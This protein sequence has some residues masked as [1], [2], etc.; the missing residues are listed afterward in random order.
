MARQKTGWV[1]QDEKERWFYRFQYTD[2]TG[3]RRNVRRLAT[4]ESNAKTA[5]RK[6]LNKHEQTGERSIEGD[7]LRFAKLVEIFKEKRVFE[8][9]YHG[10]RKVAGLRSY[11]SVELLLET[12]GGHFAN[13]LV[14]TITHSDVEQFK[15]ERLRTLK[16][17]KK[18]R[19]IASVNRELEC[20][21][22]VMNFAKREGYIHITPFE[23]GQALISKSD[24]TR[25]DRVLSRE[26]EKRLLVACGERTYTY[27][28]KGKEI[29]AHDTGERRQLL[30]VIIICALDTALRRGEIFK[31]KWSDIDFETYEIKVK[32]MNSKT[33]RPRT[34][35]MTPRLHDELLNLW[36]KSPKRLSLSV[37]GYDKPESTIKKAW[38]GACK[39]A[40][41][42]DFRFHDLRHSAITRLVASGEPSANVMKISGH[43]QHT[44]FQRYVN[45]NSESVK[46]A[47]MRLHKYNEEKELV[48]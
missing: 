38:A 22:S 37:F 9:K 1:G 39:D 3:R 7:R 46:V 40:G 34:V 36:N 24:E 19:T 26:E 30:K 15:L 33:A 43:T 20:L 18:E 5:L 48:N 25:R 13:K 41:L 12:L 32:A 17:N 44:T 45:P 42:Q 23:R 14:K 11:K 28:R 6:A 31:L 21:R 27:K 4:S 47:A 10:E 16:K 35:E 8:A 2:A 29:T